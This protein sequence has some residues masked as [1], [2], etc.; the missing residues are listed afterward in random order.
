MNPLTPGPWKVVQPKHDPQAWDV[1]AEN[2]MEICRLPWRCEPNA[3]LI[4]TAPDLLAACIC[5]LSE[6]EIGD[7]SHTCAALLRAAIAKAQGLSDG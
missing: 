7:H 1:A 5:A 2:G 3:R 4:A 6:N